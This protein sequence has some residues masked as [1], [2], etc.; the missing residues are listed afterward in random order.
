MNARPGQGSG[1][2]A[3]QRD[4]QAWLVRPSDAVGR[5][6]GPPARLAV[7]QNNYR[8]Q[9]VGCLQESYPQVRRWLGE[10]VFLAAAVRH[11]DSRPPHDWTLDAYADGFPDALA[12]AFPDNPDLHELAW[13]EHALHAAFVARDAA[14]AP[15]ADWSRVDWETA[16][17][18]FAPSMRL[19]A[20]LTNAGVIWE[21]LADGTPCPAGEM[22]A[23]PGG[24]LVWRRGHQC[25][26]RRLDGLEYDALL[27]LRR[28]GS[29]AGL[30]AWL[31]ERV[32]EA[33]GVE[34]AG[35]FLGGW[36]AG[37]LVVG[38]GAEPPDDM[39][40]LTFIDGENP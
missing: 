19:R 28:D 22:L 1:L 34:R 31:V 26:L 16:R 40:P 13:I 25:V 39:P 24:L 35:A 3:L 29:F 36:L 32:G 11:I 4:F 9:L 27:R 37:R 17:V 21:A 12:E 38:T 14:C 10:D 8:T 2:A 23:A 7:Y 6:L 20:A 18:R 15:D 33:Q 30:C 5:R